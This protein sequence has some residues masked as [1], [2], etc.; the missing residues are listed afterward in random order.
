MDWPVKRSLSVIA[1]LRQLRM[2]RVRPPARWNEDPVIKACRAA[3][4]NQ[5]TPSV[6]CCPANNQ[7]DDPSRN[8]GWGQPRTTIGKEVAGGCPCPADPTNGRQAKGSE[9]CH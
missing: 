9:D 3:H 5:Q 7:T 2:R 4:D 1:I 8:L 6:L